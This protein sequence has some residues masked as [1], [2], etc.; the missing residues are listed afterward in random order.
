MNKLDCDRTFADSGG[1]PFHRAVSNVADREDAG[2]VRLQQTG[3]ALQ[4]PALWPFARPEEI[5]TR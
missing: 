5:R 4:R 2:D 3:I 1:D